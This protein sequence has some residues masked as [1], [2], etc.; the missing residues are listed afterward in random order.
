MKFTI[1]DIYANISGF[2]KTV[3]SMIITQGT[4]CMTDD[5]I[6]KLDISP[7]AKEERREEV[8]SY[9]CLL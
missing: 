7:A 4:K 9:S 2:L 8:R 6:E 1:V 5:E 3:S